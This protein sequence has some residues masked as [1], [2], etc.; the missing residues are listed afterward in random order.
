[1][2]KVV[3]TNN[4]ELKRDRKG[5]T[6]HIKLPLTIGK[7]YVLNIPNHVMIYKE[8]GVE[9]Y[10]QT[11]I[12]YEISEDD[13]GLQNSYNSKNFVTVEVWREMQITKII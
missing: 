4:I 11:S 2:I 7:T 5:R 3:C 12:V 10:M 6:C 8:A 13:N 1:M 9:H